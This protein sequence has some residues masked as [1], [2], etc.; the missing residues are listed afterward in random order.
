MEYLN[1]GL[2]SLLFRYTLCKPAIGIDVQNVKKLIEIIQHVKHT[3][4][5]QFGK[6]LRRFETMSSN[7]RSVIP[8]YRLLTVEPIAYRRA[9]KKA[10][11]HPKHR[12][13][14]GTVS[15]WLNNA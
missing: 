8:E 7:S 14:E 10:D 1:L 5:P 15:P 3:S 11:E 6:S 13:I 2:C 4:L 12:A 9:Y